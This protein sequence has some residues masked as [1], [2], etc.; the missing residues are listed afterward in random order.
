MANNR[1]VSTN[2]WK[3]NYVVDLDPTEKLLFL[4]LL[5]N[6][7]TNVA[8]IYE[9]N[10]REVSFDTGYDIEM[11]K[12]I[13]NRFER[14]GK[15]Q[16]ENGYILLTNW[17]KHQSMNP[18]VRAGIDRIVAGLPTWLH[19]L[20]TQDERTG[21]LQIER[22]ATG[23]PVDSLGTESDIL[24]LTLLN[25][26]LPNVVSRRRINKDQKATDIQL[27][28]LLNEK[29]NRQFRTLPR[30]Y[31]KTLEL[32]TLE[33]IGQAFDNMMQSPWHKEKIGE[34]KTEYLLR[35]STIDEFLTRESK[36]TQAD[37]LQQI[38]EASNA[39]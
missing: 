22:T 29:T 3:D 25:S 34:L 13:F 9:I 12:R 20:I 21:N 16:Y 35:A 11:V 30:G 14:D 7:K 2:F 24:N 39:S 27:L 36:T 17:V 31:K 8:G 6:P 26:T 4:Y 37:W 18:S 32:F 1:Q 23:Q 10:L 15:V 19:D 5:T 28:A 33:E 38:K